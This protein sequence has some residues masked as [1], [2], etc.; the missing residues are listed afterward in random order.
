MFRYQSKNEAKA[1]DMS[2]ILKKIYC[3]FNCIR[4]KCAET[5]EWNRKISLSV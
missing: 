3:I 1:T 2:R 5:L 4:K